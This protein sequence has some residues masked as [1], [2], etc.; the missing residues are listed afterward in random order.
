MNR[1][2]LDRDVWLWK[3]GFGVSGKEK[4]AGLCIQWCS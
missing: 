4:G 2:V 1:E 3:W